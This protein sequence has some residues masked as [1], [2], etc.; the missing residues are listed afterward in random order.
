MKIDKAELTKHALNVLEIEAKAVSQLSS[1]VDD[2]FIQACELMLN[3][4][5]RVIVTGM[6]KSGHIG[7]KMA[8]TLAS[9]GT[10]AL[11]VHPGEASHGDLGMITAQD[12]V[13]ALSN[14]GANEELLIITPL[15]KRLHVPLIALTGRPQSELAKLSDV[16]IDIG[17]DQEACSLGLAPTAS[18]TATLAMCDA[19]A[20]CLLHAKG[21]TEEDFARSHP[22]G[23]LGRQ[24]LVRIEDIMHQGEAIP[25]V[26]ETATLKEAIV[27]MS[28]KRLGM[29]TVVK[30]NA[31]DEM[32]GLFTDGDLRRTLDKGLDLNTTTVAEVMTQN[33]RTANPKMLASEA[34]HIMEQQPKVLVLPVVNDKKQLVGAFNM[35]DLIQARVL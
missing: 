18:T 10:P 27:E 14:S 7:K 35:H 24:L 25:K 26:P 16:H 8:A 6:G 22:G 31:H 23:K 11:F 32:I 12:V 28:Q 1:K 30:A 9:T 34:I 13:L 5:G 17:V 2:A 19:L 4:K 33:F 3:A 15:I 29:T 20:M 21:F